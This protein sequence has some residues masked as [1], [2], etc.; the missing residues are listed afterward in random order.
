MHTA[1]NLLQIHQTNAALAA[2]HHRVTAA[3]LGGPPTLPPDAV[4]QYLEAEGPPSYPYIHGHF[5]RPG[6]EDTVRVELHTAHLRA[7]SHQLSLRS[8]TWGRLIPRA[9]ARL[10]PWR[11]TKTS[12]CTS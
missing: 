12:Q 3:S 7:I 5:T 11:R 2:R 10:N 8:H 1:T 6:T 9:P 4:L